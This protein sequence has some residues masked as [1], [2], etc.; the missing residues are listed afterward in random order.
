MAF[1]PHGRLSI[2]AE[3][4]STSAGSDSLPD[5]IL[6]QIL[7]PALKV[8]DEDFSNHS[9]GT[10][11]TYSESTSAFLLVCKAWLRVATPLLYHTV[12]VRSKGQAKALSQTILENHDLAQFIKKLRVEGGY[13]APMH[14]ILKCSPNISDIFL[15]LEIRASDSTTGLCKGL[16]LI[17]PKRIIL[18]DTPSSRL[19][20]AMLL[21]LICA[22]ETSSSKWDRLT[23]VELPYTTWGRVIE[24]FVGSASL[25][26]VVIPTA[27]LHYASKIAVSLKTTPLRQ[28]DEDPALKA[29]VKFTEKDSIT[30]TA[31]QSPD[32]EHSFQ[33]PYIPPPNPRYIPMS[34]TSP[35]V[36]REIWKRVI[37][38]AMFLPQLE[39][40]PYR[41]DVPPRLPLL[42]VSKMFYSLALISYYQYTVL[43]DAKAVEAL[44]C[45]LSCHP[46]IAPNVLSLCGE[47]D[48]PSLPQVFALLT[49]LTRV[50]SSKREEFNQDHF[51]ISLG[52]GGISWRAFSAMATA[53]GSTLL[54]LSAH[55]S[56]DKNQS[57]AI[58]D[59]I[60][61]LR[62]VDWKCR[63]TFDCSSTVVPHHALSNLTDLRLWHF[64]QSL[65]TILASMEL[66]SLRRLALSDDD[67]DAT[68]FLR[69]H[70]SKLTELDNSYSTVR[71]LT[72]N[73]FE[74]CQNLEFI[75]IY[76]SSFGGFP[77]S[78]E[79]FTFDSIVHRHLVKMRISQDYLLKRDIP[80][81]DPV[82]SSF[83][84]EHFP[85]L[86]EIETTCC[87]WP[88]TEREIAKS[89]WVR[90]A[91]GLLR[92]DIAMTDKAGKRWRTRVGQQVVPRVNV[93]AAKVKRGANV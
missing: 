11:A 20:S 53:A 71:S 45:V 42:M 5:E 67:I 68:A 6:S 56:A 72:T 28:L 7:S 69:A 77:P 4:I 2:L 89:H 86:R 18:S 82:F 34:S 74:L 43:K 63:T 59:L 8:S 73:V 85:Q 87:V 29:L 36:Q 1:F 16:C 40:D 12:V 41:T 25:D 93:R 52:G 83:V 39:L 76:F 81:W 66:A 19:V 21:N 24:I 84:P 91:E 70:G 32:S 35:L 57:P 3:E 78:K 88:T 90:W 31:Q 44:L 79:Q 49:G 13:G 62:S 51:D 60:D 58:F 22:L 26:T 46:Y 48:H 23:T 9:P 61:G 33:V 38:H 50:C 54:E 92:N 65:L 55:I 27:Q 47:S 14:T 64:D 30:E 17:N 80:A 15:S 37:Y 75:S 10:F